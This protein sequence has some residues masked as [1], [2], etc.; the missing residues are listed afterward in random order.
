[1]TDPA[2]YT[3]MTCLTSKMINTRFSEPYKLAVD[4]PTSASDDKRLKLGLRNPTEELVEAHID[5]L[6]CSTFPACTT[7]GQTILDRRGINAPLAAPTPNDALST[8][9][10]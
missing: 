2:P 5:R 7:T 1:V 6:M 4:L 9:L 10:P 3:L 8:P